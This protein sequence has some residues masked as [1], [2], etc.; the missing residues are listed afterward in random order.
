MAVS[1]GTLSYAAAAAAYCFLSVLLITMVFI[2]KG[3]VIGIGGFQPGIRQ[4]PA[5]DITR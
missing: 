3:N 2:R 5:F 1:I 4:R